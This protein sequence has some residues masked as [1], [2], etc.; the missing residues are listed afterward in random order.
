[1]RSIAD[2]AAWSMCPSS[3]TV[4]PRRRP[5]R[6]RTTRTSTS[7][8]SSTPTTSRSRSTCCSP[9][10]PP[11]NGSTRKRPTSRTRTEPDNPAE[12]TGKIV[13][14]P[15][16]RVPVS[17]VLPRQAAQPAGQGREGP[18]PGLRVTGAPT[19]GAS[20]RGQLAIAAASGL[21]LALAFPGPDLGPLALVALV[22]LLLAVARRHR[23]ARRAPRVRRRAGVLRDPPVV[24]VVLRCDRDRSARRAPSRVLGGGRRSRRRVRSAG[25]P[26][27][28]PDRRVV[29]A[30]RSARGRAGRSVGSRG[31]R[32]ASRC[33]AT[34]SDARS[35]VGVASRSSRS[36]SSRS[37]DFVRR[38]RPSDARRIAGA[39]RARSPGSVGVAVGR[40][41]RDR[42]ALR[43]PT[44]RAGC[45][46]RCS[47]ATTRTG[48]SPRPSSD[49]LPDPIAPRARE[50]AARP[51]RP[52]RVPRVV[53]RDRPEADPALRAELTRIARRH[54][55]SVMANVIDEQTEPGK[56]FNANRLYTPDGR[57]AGTYAKRHLVPFG[58]FVPWR[59][60]L[61]FISEL[62]QIPHDFTPGHELGIETVA[63]TPDRQRD[64][65][66]ERVRPA[67][68]GERRRGRR[69]DRR[70][71]Q[72]PLVP[73]VGELGP[74]RRAESDERGGDRP[75]GAALVDLGHHRGHRCRR[76]GAPNDR[77]VPEHGGDRFDH[78]P[79]GATPR[80]SGSAT[81]WNGGA[82]SSCLAHRSASP[83]AAAVVSRLGRKERDV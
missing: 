60:S 67:D 31:V 33:T 8:K 43:R 3:R 41:R 83:S 47:R 55:S 56:A 66:R 68:A 45:G 73:A 71:H 62:Q 51:L 81:G 28:V 52:H 34:T 24:D 32:S 7:R 5:T 76:R 10:A 39:R 46:S 65:L 48:T 13:P 11:P 15:R 74:A 29:G 72:Q 59:D 42:H 63:R 18:L 54:H 50:T 77:V 23:E 82:R 36:S 38:P 79:P 30:L 17:V 49:E 57:L 70:D 37:T 78:R 61:S 21:L 35:R 27:A 75:S 12:G 19:S 9:S 80:T 14:A 16:R 6:T 22:P 44:R 58:E 1:M 53:A 69:G 4:R 2:P 40:G 20:R 26:L 25:D 64:L